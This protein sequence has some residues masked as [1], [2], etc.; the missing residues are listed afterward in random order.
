MLTAS[1]IIKAFKKQVTRKDLFES[2]PTSLFCDFGMF[3]GIYNFFKY[4]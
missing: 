1:L 3:I 2:L 4:Y